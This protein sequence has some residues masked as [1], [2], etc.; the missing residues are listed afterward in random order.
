[1]VLGIQAGDFDYTIVPP[2]S[3][4][5]RLSQDTSLSVQSAPP[6]AL[7]AIQFNLKHPQLKEAK[8]REAISRAF[9]R[10]KFQRENMAVIGKVSTGPVV[11][12]SWAY[13]DKVAAPA[14][15]LSKAK[16]L[17]AEAGYPNGGFSVTIS[18]NSGNTYREEGSTILQ[19]SLK[20]LGIDAR[21]DLG[22][23]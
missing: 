5:P 10:E 6:F 20:Q 17:M 19:A 8:V 21:L 9:D 13:D 12:G 23:W 14:Y 16:Q 22:E 18:A 4:V 15:D 3:E 1:L 2:P 11:W 7:E